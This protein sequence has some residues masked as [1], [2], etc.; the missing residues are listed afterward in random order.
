ME[1]KPKITKLPDGYANGYDTYGSI[2]KPKGGAESKAYELKSRAA[3]RI[4]ML[5]KNGSQGDHLTRKEEPLNDDRQIEDLEFRN[6]LAESPKLVQFAYWCGK[7]ND[8][9]KE[10]NDLEA[11]QNKRKIDLTAPT[12]KIQIEVVENTIRELF[13]D[14]KKERKIISRTPNTKGE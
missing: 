3:Q 13:D 1:K 2:C 6:K 5:M 9:R 14:I 12:I 7:L 4:T 8:L 11:T 10:L